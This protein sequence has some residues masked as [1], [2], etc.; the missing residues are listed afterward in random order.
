[1]NHRLGNQISLNTKRSHVKNRNSQGGEGLGVGGWGAYA[2][3]CSESGPP[4]WPE[5]ILVELG[6]E[7]WHARKHPVLLVEPLG[8]SIPTSN[9]RV[10]SDLARDH[11]GVEALHDLGHGQGGKRAD[12]LLGR[13]TVGGRRTRRFG[14]QETEDP[15]KQLGRRHELQGAGFVLADFAGIE[16]CAVAGQCR[17]YLLNRLV[18]GLPE[19][20]PSARCPLHGV[21]D[22][23]SAESARNVALV[24]SLNILPVDTIQEEQRMHD[25]PLREDFVADRFEMS[26]EEALQTGHG[27]L[28]AFAGL[29]E[30]GDD[31]L[32]MGEDNRH[33]MLVFH[34]EPGLLVRWRVFVKRVLC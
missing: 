5:T 25:S 7:V 11:T 18:E 32:H 1:M 22:G 28:G 3:N 19:D 8:Q 29:L 26:L 27:V 23:Q 20:R 4:V 21:Q 15:F 2:V 24:V 6:N 10:R 16:S 12:Q 13:H 9:T 30:Q 17:P 31:F 33:Q 34:A 14:E